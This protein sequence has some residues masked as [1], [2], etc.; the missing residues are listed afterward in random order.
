MSIVQAWSSEDGRLHLRLPRGRVSSKSAAACLNGI[1]ALARA[2]PVFVLVYAEKIRVLDW[3][4]ATVLA[5]D[6]FRSLV[7][8]MAV[9]VGASQDARDALQLFTYFHR[10]EYPLRVFDSD[11]HAD[12]WL[13]TLENGGAATLRL[14]TP[15]PRFS[16]RSPPPLR[17]N[18]ANPYAGNRGQQQ[19]LTKK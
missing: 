19:Q 15:V 17:V 4:A 13:A 7:R 2:E 10:P 8:A 9:V 5:S 14:R 3:N 11:Q 18:P 6:E 16:P 12:R 1:K